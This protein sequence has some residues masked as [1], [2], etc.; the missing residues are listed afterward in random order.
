MGRPSLTSCP[1]RHPMPRTTVRLSAFLASALVLLLLPD[2]GA[3]Q[4]AAPTATTSAAAPS[5]KINVKSSASLRSRVESWRWFDTTAAGDYQFAAL[6]GRVGVQ[7][8][9]GRWQLRTDLSV[10]LLMGLPTD[11]TLPAPL[12][13]LGLGAAYAAASTTTGLPRSTVAGVFVRQAALEW[14]NGTTVARLGRFDVS[15]GVERTPRSPALTSLKNTRVA[16]RLLG[17]FGFTHGQRANDGLT[18]QTTRAG[19][20][21]TAIAV[22]PTSGVFTV[23][24]TGQS[25][26][27]NI[28]YG[29]W[30]SGGGGARGE[31]DARLFGLWYQ[32]ERALVPTDNRSA[33]V[34]AAASRAI[35]INTAGGHLVGV[36]TV[37]LWQFDGLAWGAVQNGNWSTL[38]HR[39]YALAIEGGVQRP[40]APWAPWL[41]AGW[42]RG[43]GDRD[44]ADGRHGTFFQVAPTPRLYARFPFYNGMNSDERF[45]YLTLKPRKTLSARIGMHEVHLATVNDLWLL[46]G[47]AFDD[48]AFGYV[49]RPV[50]SGSGTRLGLV[51]ES[52]LE[53]RPNSHV[54][55]EGFI[56]RATRAD[57]PARIYGAGSVGNL[58]LME[59]TLT[60]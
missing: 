33:T 3:S 40:A 22:R 11:A 24:R 36:R 19:H 59:L 1:P 41:R 49:G 7:A 30:S 16:Q 54:A 37:Q 5:G 17:P 32:D 14:K 50:P 35:T 25:L 57:L 23:T 29:A 10:P 56:A 20:T 2:T 31:W 38:D 28:G 27:V 13:Q 43:S 39:A 21:F 51:M 15:D 18:L 34:R 45:A 58:A 48:R 44:A 55:L 47:G 42:Y 52:S 26:P 60:R 46:G 8:S 4:S 12:G 6:L 9:R 53:W